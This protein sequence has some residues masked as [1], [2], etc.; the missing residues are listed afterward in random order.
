MMSAALEKS[1][2]PIVLSLSPGPTPIDEAEDL[3]KY[4]QLWRISDDMWDTW[5]APEGKT[6]PAGLV[7]QFNLTAKWAPHIETGQLARRRHV[8]ARLTSAQARGGARRVPRADG[9]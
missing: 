1:G 7:R 2:R 4:A 6:F 8:A 3:R 9:R 5:S